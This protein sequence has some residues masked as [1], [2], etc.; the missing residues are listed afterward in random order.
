MKIKQKS[1]RPIIKLQG[2][3]SLRQSQFLRARTKYVAYGGARG[4][5]KSWALRR[6]CLILAF[7]FPGVRIL[8][9]R[10]TLQE[11][12]ENHT[13]PLK[14]ELGESIRYIA[15]EKAF[16]FGNGSRIKLGYCDD[17]SDVDQY[18]GQ[19]YD[20]ICMDEGTQFTEFQFICLS[21]CLRGGNPGCPK[22]F[23]IT[24]N[25]GGVG[26]SWVKRLFIDRCYRKGENP[27]DYTFIPAR[28]FDNDFL[29]K[30]NPD[31]LRQLESLPEDL[32]KAWL[33]GEWEVFAGQ[34]FTEF[35]RALHVCRPFEIPAGWRRYYVQDYGLDMLAG[36]WI[37][38]SAQGRA[39]VYREIYR[40][41]LVV[42]DAASEI[43]SLERA[44]EEVFLRLA[45][46]DLW[47]RTKD[48]GKSVIEIFADNGLYFSR[49]DNNRVQGW[50]ALR[51]WLKPIGNPDGSN[52]AKL[53]IFENCTNLI[54]TLPLL[55]FDP[56][57]PN[58]VADQ[59]HELTH[60]P[61]ALRY[62][63]SSRPLSGG[64]SE[65]QGETGRLLPD[66][67]DLTQD[68]LFAGWR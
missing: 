9:L 46:P 29:M 68:Y 50:M 37:A 4:G 66:E 11:L 59:P 65:A 40:S 6:K 13:I 15:E 31:Y 47:G 45:P 16:V 26:H 18:Q 27:E 2:R 8:L 5:G 25:P 51:E 41:G 43:R 48:S 58:D 56:K 42:S 35:S 57:K 55:Q 54:R 30:Y 33:Y 64:C 63:A 52:G 3:P 53:K 10:R 24:C 62:F 21:A 39:Y 19:E 14:R 44:D 28:V 7:S 20:V 38:V 36:L 49:A 23:Y 60:A 1:A 17:Q 61:D 67:N 32:K 12:R 22:H 34:Y